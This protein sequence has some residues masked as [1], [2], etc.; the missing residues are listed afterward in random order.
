M[1]RIYKDLEAVTI[2]GQT[3]PAVSARQQLQRHYFRLVGNLARSKALLISIRREFELTKDLPHPGAWIDF[4]RIEIDAWY[5][6]EKLI[7][8]TK[9]EIQ[10][11]K[12]EE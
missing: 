9:K 4:M 2:A 3:Y 8:P 6:L 1:K 10:K 12:I 5:E 7:Y 11:L